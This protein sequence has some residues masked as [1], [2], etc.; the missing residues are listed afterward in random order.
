MKLLNSCPRLT[1]LSLTGVNAFQRD[2]FQPYC[3]QAPPGMYRRDLPILPLTG[4]QNSPNTK[5]MYSAFSLAPW[6][7]NSETFSTLH[8]NSRICGIIAGIEQQLLAIEHVLLL[9]TSPQP[10][11]ER[12]LMMRWSMMKT[13]LRDWT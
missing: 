12:E 13:T 9:P 7:P 10:P 2:D 11:L 8:P 6:C 5:E 1:H 3:R 4:S